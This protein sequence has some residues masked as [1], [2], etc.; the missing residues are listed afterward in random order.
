MTTW[1]IAASTFIWHSPLTTDILE[2]RLPQLAAW[3]FDA[4]ELPLENAGDWDVER[5]AALLTELGLD[6]VVCSAFPAGRELAV[7]R[8]RPRQPRSTTCARRSTSLSPR[9]HPW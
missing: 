6:S 7:P 2:S 5:C 8:R 9:V 3:G 4:V 1:R